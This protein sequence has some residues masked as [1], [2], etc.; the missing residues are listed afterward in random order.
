MAQIEPTFVGIPQG[1]TRLI[2]RGP[3]PNLMVERDAAKRTRRPSP[4]SL[5][6]RNPRFMRVE[7]ICIAH[8]KHGP[9]EQRP[10]AQI[11]A[12]AGIVGDRY[13]G[14]AQRYPGQNITLIE[15][16][17]IDR[18]NQENGTAITS[19]STRRNIITRGVRLVPLVGKEFTIGAVRFRGVELCEPCRLLGANLASDTLGVPQIVEKFVHRAGLRAVALCS[20]TIKVGDAISEVA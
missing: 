14:E 12:G 19:A 16:E 2:M 13:F 11:V 3:M 1:Q 9:Q 20:G 8:E 7:A 5:C 6:D 4:C 18:F 15:I 10:E 17:E